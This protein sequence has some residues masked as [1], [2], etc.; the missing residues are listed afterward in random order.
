MEG[1]LSYRD[2]GVDLDAAR[3]LTARLA[4]LVRGG[5]QGFAG[6]FP[7]PAMRDGLLVAC[8]DGVGTKVSLARRLAR[9][10]GLGQ[11]L[12]A[13]SV[14]D[15]V[16]C[17]ATPLFFLDY[18]AV[19]RLDP[20]EVGEVVAGV[21][22]ACEEA[23]CAL[24]GGETAEHPGVVPAE[25]L[26][27]AGFAVGAVERDDLLGP[28]R[29]RAG[30]AIVG[31]ASSGLHANG[32]SLVRALVDDGALAP[33]PD[34]LLA[35]TRLYA[36][37][38]AGIREAGIEIHAAAHVTGGGLPEN[39]PRAVPEGLRPV[40]RDGAWPTPAAIRAVLDTGRVAEDE[41]WRALNMGL[42]MCLIVPEAS[43]PPIV[44]SIEGAHEVGVV[45]DG[46]PGLRRA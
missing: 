35:P 23:G 32:F 3:G 42:G 12:V 16:C 39:L 37:D 13:M 24:L 28:E 46:P 21:A 22:R 34:L 8:T 15:L 7:L 5:T 40:L 31:L 9:L 33:E 18:V 36:A 20:D 26:D 38:L 43:V 1:G 10:E 44:A 11:D 25:H 4:G 19:G 29:V 2:A 17:G 14:N 41:A 30:D 45:E 27:L 6:L